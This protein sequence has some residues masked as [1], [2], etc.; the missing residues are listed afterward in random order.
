MRVSIVRAQCDKTLLVS[1]N[2]FFPFTCTITIPI[3]P[4][5]A[6]LVHIGD[7]H[8]PVNVAVVSRKAC[9]GENAHSVI[10]FS[11]YLKRNDF[12]LVCRDTANT[13]INSGYRLGEYRVITIVPIIGHLNGRS[14]DDV[15]RYQYSGRHSRDR[16]FQYLTDFSFEHDF[17][18][19]HKLFLY[20]KPWTFGLVLGIIFSFKKKKR[21]EFL[22]SVLKYASRQIIQFIFVVRMADSRTKEYTAECATDL[23]R[24]RHSSQLRHQYRQRSQD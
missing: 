14:A 11:L 16:S 13:V 19:F 8:N 21:L 23:F 5:V 4:V 7:N 9:S 3:L 2:V 1:R 6:V 12:R 10:F 15:R 24:V 18:P 17:S 22:Q 20:V